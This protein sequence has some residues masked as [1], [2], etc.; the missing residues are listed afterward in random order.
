MKLP[1]LNLITRTSVGNKTKKTFLSLKSKIK[2][3]E[4]T[5]SVIKSLSLFPKSS[6]IHLAGSGDCFIMQNKAKVI[7][8]DIGYL[9]MNCNKGKITVH[10]A[11]KVTSKYN[12]GKID[13]DG[14]ETI[15]SLSH[16]AGEVKIRNVKIADNR[17]N[18]GHID[19][20]YN[21]R[22]SV[23]FNN[24]NK[25][26]IDMYLNDGKIYALFNEG[27]I[28]CNG[29]KRFINLSHNRA[30]IEAKMNSST[31]VIKN[32]EG[33]LDTIANMGELID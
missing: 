4:D 19:A 16:N 20:N 22:G 15:A 10:N 33:K 8:N 1:S 12:G 23:Q 24:H 30:E 18:K 2:L 17:Y 27:E 6:T 29:N 31:L 9:K 28:H 21:P 25:D 32:N 14:V 11:K 13:I 5:V 7:A 26:T 3:P